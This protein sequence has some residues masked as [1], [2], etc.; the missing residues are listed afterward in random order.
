[1]SSVPFLSWHDHNDLNTWESELYH[2][3]ADLAGLTDKPPCVTKSL[4]Y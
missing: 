1:M 4:N 2:L 3:A